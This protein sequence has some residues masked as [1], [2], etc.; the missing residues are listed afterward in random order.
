LTPFATELCD[1]LTTLTPLAPI[2]DVPARDAEA[3]LT[4]V[5][6]E[7][8]AEM[9]VSVWPAVTLPIWLSVIA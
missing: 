2:S 7:P 4:V 6:V 8:L 9:E 1:A 3:A 5:T